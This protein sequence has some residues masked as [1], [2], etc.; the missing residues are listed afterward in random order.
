MST[1][2]PS[3][4]VCRPRFAD[5]HVGRL[6]ISYD[7]GSDYYVIVGTNT[8]RDVSFDVLADVI[9]RELG[10]PNWGQVRIEFEKYQRRVS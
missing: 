3:R 7:R 5:G 1:D 2:K 4:S 10:A 6:E 9:G 8:H